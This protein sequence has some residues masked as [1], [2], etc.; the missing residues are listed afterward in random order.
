[1]PRLVTDGDMVSSA[2]SP[3][4]QPDVNEGRAGWV[5]GSGNGGNA[6]SADHPGGAKDALNCTRG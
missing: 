5:K 3:V 4:L 6:G 1:M 2:V